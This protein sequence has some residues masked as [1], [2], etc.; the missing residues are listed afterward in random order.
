MRFNFKVNQIGDRL[1]AP[2]INGS[3]FNYPVII[4]DKLLLCSINTLLGNSS[5]LKKDYVPIPKDREQTV[6]YYLDFS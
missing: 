3:I 4:E 1:F 2:G 5:I 6:V